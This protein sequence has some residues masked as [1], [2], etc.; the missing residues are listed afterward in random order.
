MNHYPNRPRRIDGERGATLILVAF[1]M[2]GFLGFAALA[3]DIGYLMVVRNQLQNAADAAALGGAMKLYTATTGPN[4]SDAEAQATA[5]IPLNTVTNTALANGLVQSGYYNLSGSVPGLHAT[6]GSGDAPAVQVTLSKSSGNNGG[7]VSLFFAPVLGIRTASVAANA[8][9]VESF[10]GS[11]GPGQLFPTAIAKCLYDNFWDSTNNQPKTG[12]ACPVQPVGCPLNPGNPG[13]A[14]GCEFCI[15]SAYHYPPCE[16]GEWS[17]FA[18]DTNDVPT[19]RGLIA[20]GNPSALSIGD[21][22][23]IEPGTKNTIYTA[24]QALIG[25]K[26][27]FP[28][29]SGDLTS[30][31]EQPITGFACLTIDDSVGASSKYILVHMSMGCLLAL[32]G[33]GGP[34]YGVLTPPTLVK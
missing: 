2:I 24:A 5:T 25:T 21:D 30:K 27:A 34:N 32:G 17:S 7:P 6:Q 23:W 11:V 28:I 18:F 20:N 26:V 33:P 13:N 12:A 10:P 19:V 31:G 1:G 22:I 8:V 14:L 29:V 3:V 15:G 9:A 16:S 4:W